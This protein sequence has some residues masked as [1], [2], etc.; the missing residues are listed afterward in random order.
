MNRLLE[1]G[2]WRYKYMDCA[3]GMAA[4]SVIHDG[5]ELVGLYFGIWKLN[6][7]SLEES[8]QDTLWVKPEASGKLAFSLTNFLGLQ[9]K[10]QIVDNI[11]ALH[12]L[13]SLP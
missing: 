5:E 1:A 12:N 13:R 9:D 10:I 2:Y 4:A 7:V 6:S 8:R 11:L 3:S